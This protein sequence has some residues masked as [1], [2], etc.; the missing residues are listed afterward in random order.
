MAVID[1]HSRS[2]S[3]KILI[4]VVFVRKKNKYIL[5]LFVVIYML[6]PMIIFKTNIFKTK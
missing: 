3:F 5:G 4:T 1:L 2:T 6:I